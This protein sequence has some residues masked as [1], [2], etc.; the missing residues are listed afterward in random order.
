MTPDPMATTGSTGPAPFAAGAARHRAA[1]APEAPP[2]AP[3]DTR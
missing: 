3:G 2:A 1:P